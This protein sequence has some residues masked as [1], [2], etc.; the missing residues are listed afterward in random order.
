MVGIFSR[1]SG[2]RISS[3]RRSQSVMDNRE[4]PVPNAEAEGTTVAVAT[5]THGF[6]VAVEFKPVEHPIEPLNNDQPVKCPLPEPSILNDGRIWKERMSAT[7]R[8]STDLPVMMEGNPLESE[9]NGSRP[10]SS[11]PNRLILPSLSAPEHNLINM[12]EECNAA[13]I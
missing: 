6:E 4:V 1:F 7:V 5:A 12:L 9:S 3:H 13:G 11:R 10:R 2:G 8:R